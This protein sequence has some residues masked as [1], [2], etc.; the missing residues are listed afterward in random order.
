VRT[1]LLLG[2]ALL[3][4]GCRSG[5]G[6]LTV[7]AAASLHEALDEI[8]RLY[9]PH[10]RVVM[11]YGSSGMLAQQIERGAPADVFLP[12]APQPM[13]GLAAKGL[14]VPGTR[15]NL[16]RNR[17]VLVT[18][19][20]GGPT[21]FEALADPRWKLIALGDPG[22]VPAGNYGKQVLTALHL[23]GRVQQRLVLAQDVR[24]VLGYVETGNADA[25]IVYATDAQTSAKVRVAEVAPE[26]T[27]TPVLYPVAVLTESAHP[28][29][30]R[31]FVD[32]LASEA[33]RAVFTRHGFTVAE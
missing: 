22:S 13:D 5:G 7:C 4:A 9:A 10:Q 1:R 19:L 23:W 29:E 30:A 15:R 32:F 12:A 31:A 24:Q 26:A 18:P 8:Q 3:A 17:I 28:R 27:H 33:A 2:L 11:S 21:T 14:L 16:L 20:Q 6:E 25:G